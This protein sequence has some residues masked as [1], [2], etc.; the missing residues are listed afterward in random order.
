LEEKKRMDKEE[1]WFQ[2]ALGLKN[3]Y[4]SGYTSLALG[5][6]SNGNL[7]ALEVGAF[8]T[9]AELLPPIDQMLV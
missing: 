7:I 5:G 1:G 6:Q 3:M 2:R 8:S 9:H 4:C